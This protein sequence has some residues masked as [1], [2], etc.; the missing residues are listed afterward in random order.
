MV[1]YQLEFLSDYTKEDLPFP[2]IF[3]WGLRVTDSPLPLSKA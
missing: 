2:W 3:I 1:P